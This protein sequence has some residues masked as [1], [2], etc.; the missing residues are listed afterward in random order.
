MESR[1]RVAG[2]PVHPLLLMF[3]LGLF[4]MAIIFDVASRLG[5]PGM[6]STLA[7]WNVVAGLVGGA[8]AVSVAGIDTASAR[9]GRTAVLGVLLDLGVLV[10]FA[11]IALIRLRTADRGTDSGLLA[12]ELAGLTAA[13]FSAR[14]GGRFGGRRPHAGNRRDHPVEASG[15]RPAP[16]GTA[17]TAS[18]GNGYLAG[19]EARSHRRRR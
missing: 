18:T 4:S 2:N 13:G 19:D 3:P 15:G 16:N 14:F 11:V 8:A 1:L 9:H 5:A 10:M 6:V 17:R 7:F 12:L